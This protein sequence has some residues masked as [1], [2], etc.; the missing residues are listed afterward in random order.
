MVILKRTIV[1]LLSKPIINLNGGF[2]KNVLTFSNARFPMMGWK[3]D[4]DKWPQ[5]QK[6]QLQNLQA[7]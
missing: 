1:L 4:S 7:K 5:Q 2:K 6:K 3:I